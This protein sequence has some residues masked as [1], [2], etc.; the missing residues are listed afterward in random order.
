[1]RSEPGFAFRKYASSERYTERDSDVPEER[2]RSRRV[3]TETRLDREIECDQRSVINHDTRQAVHLILSHPLLIEMGVPQMRRNKNTQAVGCDSGS[4]G[5]QNTVRKPP[6]PA[7]G[8]P[9]EGEV[10]A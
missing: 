6:R 4:E 9:A 8:R 1:M 2:R 3:R 7:G 10:D 5:N